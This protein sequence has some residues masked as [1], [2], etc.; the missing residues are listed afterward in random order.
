AG[1]NS[2]NEAVCNGVPMLMFPHQFEQYLIAKKIE[3]MGIG[4]LMSIKKMTPDILY[5][6][7]H[8]LINDSK[9]K[10]RAVKYKAL[11]SEEEK[12][13]HVKAA[14][15]IEGYIRRQKDGLCS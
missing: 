3:K 1:M 11:F 7:V 10:E 15:E 4:R 14:D 13:A 5:N 12:I 8:E 9:F 2:V 6:L